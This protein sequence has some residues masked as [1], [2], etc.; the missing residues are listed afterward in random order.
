MFDVNRFIHHEILDANGVAS[1]V[2]GEMTRIIRHDPRN[3]GQMANYS[4]RVRRPVEVQVRL[5]QGF[6]ARVE[7]KQRAI[8]SPRGVKVW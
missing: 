8:Y 7:R 1:R 5:E 6:A 3:H 4:A 2:C